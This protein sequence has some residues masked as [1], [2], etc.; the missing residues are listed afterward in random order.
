[1]KKIMIAALLGVVGMT[2]SAQTK[3]VSL[4]KT[5]TEFLDRHFKQ[6][7]VTETKTEKDGYEV[8]LTNGM[9]V[10]FDASGNYREV[11]GHGKAIPTDFIDANIVDYVMANYPGKEITGIE[12][13]ADKIEVDLSG[14]I[15]LEFDSKGKFKKRD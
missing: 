7:T 12:R 6:S 13:K 4:P 11:D 9:E 1:M 10:E 15:G 8:K 5:A 2:A 14:N 3:V